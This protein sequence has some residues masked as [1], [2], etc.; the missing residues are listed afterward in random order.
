M[1]GYIKKTQNLMSNINTTVKCF[2]A[3]CTTCSSNASGCTELR[4]FVHEHVSGVPSR[5]VDAKKWR[6]W[7]CK[8]EPAID[9][10][11]LAFLIFILTCLRKVCKLVGLLDQQR[12][13]TCIYTGARQ[14]CGCALCGWTLIGDLIP[15]FRLFFCESEILG[16]LHKH[17]QSLPVCSVVDYGGG[18]LEFSPPPT[19]H[20]PA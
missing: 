8:A 20:P 18:T 15:C 6:Q 19:P 9:E 14:L 13:C 1:S 2:S 16:T 10:N 3:T 12:Y 11:C 4:L 17:T 5:G 7:S